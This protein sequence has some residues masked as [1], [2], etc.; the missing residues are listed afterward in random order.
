MSLKDKVKTYNFWISLVSAVVLIVRIIGD[1]FNF[2]V[3]TSLIMDITTGLCS[4]FV[5]LGILSVPKSKQTTNNETSKNID[6]ILSNINSN[7][8]LI[9]KMENTLFNTNKE[10]LEQSAETKT[11]QQ[12][13]DTNNT[14]LNYEEE[15]K[16]VSV[17]NIASIQN[18]YD[19]TKQTYPEA[20]NIVVEQIDNNEEDS[21]LNQANS[22]FEFSSNETIFIENTNNV[23]EE[24]LLVEEI[25]TGSQEAK[26][27]SF[28]DTKP[29][30]ESLSYMLE[31]LKSNFDN[32]SKQ[33]DNFLKNNK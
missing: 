12:T 16:Q 17:D 13:F 18:H 22:P 3:D 25:E 4:I 30:I 1:K 8:E 33:F 5:I 21:R 15:T 29:T 6:E 32:I 7:R 23:Q 2:I 20:H 19:P 9:T 26:D 27:P 24:N 14:Q 28:A 31:C 10:N 11:S